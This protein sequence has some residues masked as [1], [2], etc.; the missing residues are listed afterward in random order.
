MHYTSVHRLCSH[1][2]SLC[3]VFA[4]KLATRPLPESSPTHDLALACHTQ[5]KGKSYCFLNGGS[6][7][8]PALVFVRILRN[9][10]ALNSKG[11]H[12]NFNL[13]ALR[14]KRCVSTKSLR[15]ESKDMWVP[16]LTRLAHTHL[17]SQQPKS[18]WPPWR[19][20]VVRMTGHMQIR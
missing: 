3:T 19:G 1:S 20:V 8:V 14:V 9:H 10:S 7:I 15:R 18:Y 12:S 4:T 11:F 2:F 13:K 6:I 5:I 17:I 16:H